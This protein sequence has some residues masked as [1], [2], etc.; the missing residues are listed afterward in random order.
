MTEDIENKFA[1][2]QNLLLEGFK[3]KMKRVCEDVLGTFYTDVSTYAVTDAHI[4]FKNALWNEVYADFKK[5]ITSEHGQY[6]RAHTLRMDLLKNHREEISNK[7]IED[8][9]EM[10]KSKD[11]HIEQL[12]E[13]R[14]R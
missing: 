1:S 6:S 2:E 4:N 12:R 8:L 7:I 13:M 5:E 14:Y 11:E 9:Q 10:V 3:S